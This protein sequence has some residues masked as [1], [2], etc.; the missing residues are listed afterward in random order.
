M[1]HRKNLKWKLLGVPCPVWRVHRQHIF[2]RVVV[3]ATTQVATQIARPP[4]LQPPPLRL[5]SMLRCSRSQSIS[6]R[7]RLETSQK[8]QLEITRSPLPRLARPFDR[9]PRTAS[10]GSA[11]RQC[12]FC[13]HQDKRTD[14]LNW[15]GVIELHLYKQTQLPLLRSWRRHATTVDVGVRRGTDLIDPLC[16]V[17]LVGVLHRYRREHPPSMRIHCLKILQLRRPC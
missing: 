4:R 7:G 17:L 6:V 10:C 12:P 13:T 1:K 9:A 15:A 16:E 11:G 5:L 8:P 14:C 2:D 3:V